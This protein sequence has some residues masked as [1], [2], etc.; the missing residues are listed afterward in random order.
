MN[1]VLGKSILLGQMIDSVECDSYLRS[2]R[3]EVRIL[4]G[5]PPTS[6]ESITSKFNYRPRLASDRLPGLNFVHLTSM[7]EVDR[8]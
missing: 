1:S 7:L 5:V 2:K 6:V 3:S 8:G 4:S